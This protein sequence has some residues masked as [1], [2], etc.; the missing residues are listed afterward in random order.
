MRPTAAF[1]PLAAPLLGV[2]AALYSALPGWALLALLGVTA[3][4]AAA[5]VV[6]TQIIRLRANARIT[7][8]RDALRVLEIEDLPHYRQPTTRAARTTPRRP[9]AQDGVHRA[10]GT[11]THRTRQPDNTECCGDRG[12]VGVVVGGSSAEPG[13]RR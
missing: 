6:V 13:G 12:S 2:P 3:A 7:R 11:V 10:A 4:L 1:A 9:L 8:S 5:H